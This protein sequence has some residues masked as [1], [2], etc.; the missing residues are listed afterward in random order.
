MIGMMKH[1]GCHRLIGLLSLLVT[2]AGASAQSVTRS[3][4]GG[5][6]FGPRPYIQCGS[7]GADVAVSWPVTHSEGHRVPYEYGLKANYARIPDGIAGDRF[8]LGGF[9]TTPLAH[10]NRLIAPVDLSFQLGSGLGFYTRP[11]EITHDEANEFIGSVVNC[12]IDFGPVLTV[13]VGQQGGAIVL[14]GKFVHNSNGYLRKPNMGLNFLQGEVGWRFPTRPSAAR[15][16]SD[17]LRYSSRYDA[18]TGAF[19]TVAPGVTVPRHDLATNDIFY[20]AYTFQLGWRY[21]YQPC[22][23]IALATD[24]AYNFADDYACH[25]SGEQPPLPLFVGLCAQHETHWGPL[26]LRLGLGYYVWQS[27]PDGKVYERVGVFYHFGEQAR[28]SLGI[29]IK[30]NTSHA[31]F[32]EWS[33]S[34]DL[35]RI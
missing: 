10:V 12:V 8:G 18:H 3:L 26:S 14:G 30:A 6:L 16:A 9:V 29:A 1:I 24:L 33:Y 7:A 23:S 4:T 27:F 5:W 31:D 19:I 34:F 2:V 21:A 13:P 11:K 32:I 20:P 25:L 17:T 35:I 22:R 15:H 28:H